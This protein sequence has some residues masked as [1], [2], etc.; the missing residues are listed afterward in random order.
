MF[1]KVS[2]PESRNAARDQ[3]ATVGKVQTGITCAGIVIAFFY[4]VGLAIG[5]V[6]RIQF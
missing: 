1:T 6:E 4:L 2:T 3:A 5:A